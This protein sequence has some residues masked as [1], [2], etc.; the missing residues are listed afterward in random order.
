[1]ALEDSCFRGTSEW[2][3]SPQCDVR[4]E[5]SARLC[6]ER[7]PRAQRVLRPQ[8]KVAITL[9]R[10]EH[11]SIDIH[12]PMTGLHGQSRCLGMKDNQRWACIHVAQF[13]ARHGGA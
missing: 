4:W 2:L 7:T 8:L 5:S 12:Q 13:K 1:M 9:R 6:R 11:L 3:P 10:D